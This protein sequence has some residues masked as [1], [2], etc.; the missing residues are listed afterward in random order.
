MEKVIVFHPN[1][2]NET[3]IRYKAP[4]STCISC[5]T[6]GAPLRKVTN[7]YLCTP[8]RGKI[9]YKL[10]CKRTAMDVYDLTWADLAMA[11]AQG[12]IQCK[13]TPNW[14]NKNADPINLYYEK[15]I[16][17]LA[18]MK[19]NGTL[20]WD[21][22][23]IASRQ[24]HMPVVSSE[25]K[26]IPF[27]SSSASTNSNSSSSTTSSGR[28]GATVAHSD[29]YSD[30]YSR[31]DYSKDS[32]QRTYLPA[33]KPYTKPFSKSASKPKHYSTH[34]PSGSYK[35]IDTTERHVDLRSRFPH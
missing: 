12:K 24:P 33:S 11:H 31:S 13:K 1:T 34:S 22:D 21:G 23:D 20:D 18:Q 7:E 10:I 26:E 3:R 2:A 15:E 4:T 35:S 8:C 29:T 32:H 17:R 27:Y 9:D 28:F 5:G 6:D 25:Y 19:Q 14:K 16:Q 30:T